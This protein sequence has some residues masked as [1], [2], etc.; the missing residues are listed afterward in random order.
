MEHI[1]NPL[2]FMQKE[3]EENYRKYICNKITEEEYLLLIEPIDKA[4]DKLEMSTL[5][6]IPVLKESSSLY[7]QK[8]ESEKEKHDGFA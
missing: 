1:A 6:D 5:Q 4:I 2:K 3:L 7:T 8:Q